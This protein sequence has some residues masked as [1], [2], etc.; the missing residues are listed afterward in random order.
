MLALV[1][2]KI[3]A[4]AA[5]VMSGSNVPLEILLHFISSLPRE[6]TDYGGTSRMCAILQI[7]LHW[8]LLQLIDA[9]KPARAHLFIFCF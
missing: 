2:E 4:A 1:C 6:Y 5:A 9:F 8:H 3:L 7:H